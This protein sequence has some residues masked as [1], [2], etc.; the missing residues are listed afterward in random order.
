MHFV[1]ARVTRG[2]F[3]Q[4]H[5][6]RSYIRNGKR[7][8]ASERTCARARAQV[9]APAYSKLQFR[10]I[11]Q[12]P[13]ATCKDSTLHSSTFDSAHIPPLF[14]PPTAFNGHLQAHSCILLRTAVGR[15]LRLRGCKRPLWANF[16]NNTIYARATN[17]SGNNARISGRIDGDANINDLH[18][19][20]CYRVAYRVKVSRARAIWHT[21]ERAYFYFDLYILILIIYIDFLY[22]VLHLKIELVTMSFFFFS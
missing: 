10:G 2:N 20:E 3:L 22:D 15:S 13:P 18:S 17:A 19:F 7:E 1:R 9:S 14:F 4:R 6:R 12:R 16:W 11:D 5:R 21:D 8:R